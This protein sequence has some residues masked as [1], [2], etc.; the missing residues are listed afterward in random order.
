[1][2]ANTHPNGARSFERLYKLPSV[3]ERVALSRAE[4]YRRIKEG[5]FPQPVK[6]GARAVAFRGSDIDAWLVQLGNG[7]EQ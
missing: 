4:I 1:M 3:V 6:I 7:G 2:T 5:T